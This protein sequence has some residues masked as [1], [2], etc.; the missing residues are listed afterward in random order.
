M[1]FVL[2]TETKIHIN[3]CIELFNEKYTDKQYNVFVSDL[4]YVIWKF[5]YHYKNKM[6]IKNMQKQKYIYGGKYYINLKKKIF[7]IN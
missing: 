3:S 1:N 6:F 2:Y 4:K 7:N 5:K